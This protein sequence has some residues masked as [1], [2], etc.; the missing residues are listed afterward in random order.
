MVSIAMSDK[1]Y[2]VFTETEW[3][4]FQDTSQF[5]G[6]ADD[7]RDGFIHLSTKKQLAWVIKVPSTQITR[8]AIDRFGSFSF[9]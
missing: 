6:S 8:F 3:E 1:V 9:F 7:L 2:K 5:E 4:S